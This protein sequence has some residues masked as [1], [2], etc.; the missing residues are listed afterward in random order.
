M[1]VYIKSKNNPRKAWW[2][3]ECSSITNSCRDDGSGYFSFKYGTTLSWSL[4]KLEWKNRPYWP[5]KFFN[6]YA[7]NTLDELTEQHFLDFL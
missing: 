1:F 4:D 3:I 2:I 6:K 5:L 7:Y